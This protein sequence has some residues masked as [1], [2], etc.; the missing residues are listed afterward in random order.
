MASYQLPPVPQPLAVFERMI[1]PQTTTLV[2]KEKFDNFDVTALDKTRQMNVKAEYPSLHG[3]KHVY[4]SAGGHLFDITRETLHR[5]TTFSI[6]DESK[7]EYMQVQKRFAF[8][9]FKAEA[10]FTT[11]RGTPVTLKLNGDW[12]ASSA[13]IVDAASG[14]VVARIDRKWGNARE[15]LFSQQT[16]H[17]T[18][19]PGV[20]MALITAMCVCLDEARSDGG[21]S[22]SCTVM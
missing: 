13:D 5:H 11:A 8:V 4:D 15:L 20:D 9:G 2:L 14:A 19:A 21:A 3:R 16:Y 22:G 18:I 1:A 12:S 6:Q 7:K 17:V 10:T